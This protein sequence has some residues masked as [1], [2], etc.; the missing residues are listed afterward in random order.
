MLFL[1]SLDFGSSNWFF[2][3]IIGWGATRAIFLAQLAASSAHM[4]LIDSFLA[5]LHLVRWVAAKATLP[6][7]LSASVLLLISLHFFRKLQCVFVI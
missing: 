7:V 6:V 4:H 3:F 5:V 2:R 1:K